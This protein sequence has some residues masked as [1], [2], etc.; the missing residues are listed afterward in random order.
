M[1]RKEN[2]EKPK[3]QKEKTDRGEKLGVGTKKRSE[4]RDGEETRRG[5]TGMHACMVEATE[6][7]AVRVRRVRSSARCGGEGA[8]YRVE[9]RDA[10]SGR[11]G[12]KYCVF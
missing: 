8:S 6:A 10:F 12:E 2:R 1:N 3:E 9:E 7:L 11:S 4:P 5:C